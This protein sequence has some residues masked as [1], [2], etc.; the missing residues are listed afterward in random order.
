VETWNDEILG[1]SKRTTIP[2]FRHLLGK[3]LMPKSFQL[4][5]ID[6]FWTLLTRQ[7]IKKIKF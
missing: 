3:M 6:L 1:F 7:L 5:R 2:L 4:I